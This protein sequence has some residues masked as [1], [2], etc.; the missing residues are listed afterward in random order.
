MKYQKLNTSKH[1]K[2]VPLFEIA[3][4]EEIFELITIKDIPKLM[5]DIKTE[6]IRQDKYQ[7]KNLYLGI[8]YSNCKKKIKDRENLEKNLEVGNS[9]AL[10]E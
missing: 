4:E 2:E 9:T 3:E 8:S 5:T 10:E 1:G 7:K 6:N